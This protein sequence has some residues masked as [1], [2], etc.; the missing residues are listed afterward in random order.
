MRNMILQLC[1][2]MIHMYELV[3]NSLCDK[4]ICIWLTKL[5]KAYFVCFSIVL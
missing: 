4:F 1:F 3:Y 5:W 2:V